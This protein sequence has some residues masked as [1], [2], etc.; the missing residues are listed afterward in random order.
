MTYMLTIKDLDERQDGTYYTGP[1]EVAKQFILEYSNVSVFFQPGKHVTVYINQDGADGE[2]PNWNNCNEFG[3]GKDEE[4]AWRWALGAAFGPADDEFSAF[5]LTH[6]KTI[7][8][9]VLVEHH[10]PQALDVFYSTQTELAVVEDKEG[11]LWQ[12]FAD[13]TLKVYRA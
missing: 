7:A 12:V 11:D 10:F 1:L 3:N 4:D 5:P 6:N 9:R 2:V 13:G 8:V